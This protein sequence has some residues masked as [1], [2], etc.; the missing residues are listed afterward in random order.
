VASSYDHN[1]QH[2]LRRRSAQTRRWARHDQ[3]L[4]LRVAALLLIAG[5]T[6][7]VWRWPQ[8]SYTFGWDRT[9]SAALIPAPQPEARLGADRSG[10][11]VYAYSVVPGG[12]IDANELRRAVESDPVVAEHYHDLDLTRLHPVTLSMD[13][14]AYVSFRKGDR[15][16]WTTKKVRL[17]KGESVLSDGK[18]MVRARCGNRISEDAMSRSAPD[19]PLEAELDAPILPGGP[20]APLELPEQPEQG[21]LLVAA[22]RPELP[23]PPPPLPDSPEGVTLSAPVDGTITQ[24][25]SYYG[26][27]PFIHGIP[28]SWAFAAYGPT[29]LPPQPKQ[30]GDQGGSGPTTASDDPADAHTPEP[31]SWILVG[32]GMLGLGGL[33][34]RARR[35]SAR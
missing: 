32:G 7:L 30:P 25:E 9:P 29:P 12:V 16:Y 8:L 24:D 17:V 31:A 14:A 27:W 3:R 35:R 33:V 28:W 13:T 18:N 21:R 1:V 10:R 20:M 15:V 22:L 34:R 4:A 23:E 6:A 11:L 2:F 19:E 5:A 26:P